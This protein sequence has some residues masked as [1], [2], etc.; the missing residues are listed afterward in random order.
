MNTRVF[1]TATGLSLALA[2]GGCAETDFWTANPVGWLTTSQADP[3]P[4]T[5]S[6]PQSAPTQAGASAVQQPASPNPASFWTTDPLTWLMGTSQAE[7]AL[8]QTASQAEPAAT[9]GT[10]RAKAAPTQTTSRGKPAPT[11]ATSRR[12]PAPTQA[13]ASTVGSNGS[14]NTARSAGSAIDEPTYMKVQDIA[15]ND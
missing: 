15:I 1:A 3:G 5:T 10:S 9:K 14:V 12:E 8:T 4:T 11:L 6:Q 13:R 7:P 2:L